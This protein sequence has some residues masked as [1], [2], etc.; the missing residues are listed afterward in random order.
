ME[1]VSLVRLRLLVLAALGVA[2]GCAPASWDETMA[3]GQRAL[4]QGQYRK[5]EHL[6]AAA[7]RQA[8]RSGPN[9]QE[10]AQA[11]RALAGTY[12][13]Q[14]KHREAEGA[15]LR[16]LEISQAVRG[17]QH[18]DVAA[19]LE[20]LG[21][22]Y[23]RQ[24]RFTDAESALTRA[25]TIKEQLLGPEHPAVARTLRSLAR[26]HA[27]QGQF[28]RAEPLLERVVRIYEKALGSTHPEVARSL[29]EQAMLLRQ[30]GREKEAEPL[31][32]RSQAIL[33]QQPSPDRRGPLP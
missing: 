19:T 26:L 24:G 29:D 31:E 16:A 32:V 10:L 18:A 2:L 28:A 23:Q 1:N 30:M 6:F 25:V 12:E 15:Y 27:S 14:H 20:Q 21:L 8:E 13:A 9:S 7:V 17:A 4:E 3:A 22:L 11:L 5:A 33:T